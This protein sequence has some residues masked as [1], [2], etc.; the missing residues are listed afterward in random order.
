MICTMCYLEA[1]ESDNSSLPAW[2]IALI[3]TG[4]AA[5]ASAALGTLAFLVVRK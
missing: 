1:G 5:V 4:C 3:A 2:A